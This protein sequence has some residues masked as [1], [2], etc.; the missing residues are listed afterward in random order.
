[1]ILQ[2]KDYIGRFRDSAEVTDEV[3]KNAGK[4]LAKVSE[5]LSRAGLK[6]I[7]ITSGFRSVK[8]NEKIGGAKKSLHTRGLAIDLADPTKEIGQWC[9]TNMEQMAEIGLYLE[10]LERT[11]KSDRPQGRW[12]HLQSIAPNSGARVFI[13]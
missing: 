9:I 2:L 3:T 6:D 8:Y 4:L 7:A 10:S 5:L 13:P 1:M 12:V 11:H